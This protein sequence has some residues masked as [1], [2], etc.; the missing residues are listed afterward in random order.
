MS[1]I[2][3]TNN[4]KLVKQ[5]KKE[6]QKIVALAEK[7]IY[8]YE[9]D[10]KDTLNKD[11]DIFYTSVSTHLM[12]EDMSFYEFSMLEESLDKEV[13][14]QIEE[15]VDTFEKTK[16]A[17]V[18]FLT[19]YTLPDAVYDQEFIDTFKMLFGVLAKRISYEEE[20]LYK[21]LQAI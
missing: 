17:L 13:G 1:D 20:N 12:G 9:A 8:A 7:I 4:Q 2:F 11:L 14:K 6:H 16:F 3:L 5:W 19:K 15:F 10:K 18:D 21:T